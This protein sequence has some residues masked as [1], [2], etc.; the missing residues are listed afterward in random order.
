[1]ST[2][3]GPPFLPPSPNSAESVVPPASKGQKPLPVGAAD[4]IA[5]ACCC[6]CSLPPAASLLPSPRSSTCTHT[7]C[8]SSNATIRPKTTTTTRS[9][10]KKMEKGD[11]SPRSQCRSFR[12]GK[13]IRQRGPPRRRRTRK[14]SLVHSISR[15]DPDLSMPVPIC[16]QSTA[17]PFNTPPSH[18]FPTRLLLHSFSIL[19]HVLILASP[20]RVFL[21]KTPQ[22]APYPFLS[23]LPPC[24][25][26]HNT[27]PPP[28][29]PQPPASSLLI[30]LTPIPPTGIRR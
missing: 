16:Q 20:R 28:L 3:D 21:S 8:S 14:I 24:D 26:P 23:T 6:P 4:A 30:T 11:G 12:S 17:P 22:S 15:S 18:L 25:L 10:S 7:H 5:H 2:T 19:S 27:Q 1:M 13:R 9:P 29:R